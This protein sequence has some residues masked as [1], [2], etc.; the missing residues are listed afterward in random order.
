[1]LNK[2]DLELTAGFDERKFVKSVYN[3]DYILVVG[4]EVILDRENERFAYC[5]GDVNKYIVS[6]LN[7]TGYEYET[8]PQMFSDGQ[9]T[10]KQLT[11]VIENIDYDI[12][13][14]SPQ[15]LA[16]LSTKLFKF[17]IT[18]TFDHYMKTIMDHIW[19]EGEWQECNMFDDD[20]LVE[21][22]KQIDKNKIDKP[23]LFYLFGHSDKDARKLNFVKTDNDAIKLIANNWIIREGVDIRCIKDY[24]TNKRLLALGCKFEDW[25]FRF[26]WYCLKGGLQGKDS[27]GK[28][29]EGEVAISWQDTETD[30]S[31]KRYLDNTNNVSILP[32]AINFME[33]MT[34]KLFSLEP[35]SPFRD[36]IISSRKRHGIFLS[37]NTPDFDYVKNIFLTLISYGYAVWIDNE[38][39]HTGDSYTK[40]IQAAIAECR[41]FMPIISPQIQER[42][43][44]GLVNEKE[45]YYCREWG[46][47]RQ[48][49]KEVCIMPVS[50]NGA[51]N[52][53]FNLLNQQFFGIEE[54]CE[55]E[56][57]E[58]ISGT[59]LTQIGAWKKLINSIE[60]VYNKNTK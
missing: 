17:I 55:D 44:K 1:M 37:Y 8:I 18:T 25:Y 14:V 47:A 23:T 50:I 41:I 27:L 35:D 30:L 29:D 34:N 7:H 3:G 20:T 59:D 22:Q 2:K 60:K 32:D 46:W 52:V 21:F 54:D 19:G 12:Q 10:V 13:Y 36:I 53:G 31:L 45:N 33:D 5:K 51:G 16:F 42:L 56:D 43:E 40:D 48:R 9:I 26:F 11:D 57:E 58:Y 49:G 6:L 4:S 28:L 38:E 39:I 15:L 24:I